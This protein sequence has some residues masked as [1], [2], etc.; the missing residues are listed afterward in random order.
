MTLYYIL[1]ALCI[2]Y[3]LVGILTHISVVRLAR[4]EFS[5]KVLSAVTNPISTIIIVLIWPSGLIP[6]IKAFYKAIIKGGKSDIS[7]RR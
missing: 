7:K 3:I 4:R 6:I 5:D 2:G 1:V